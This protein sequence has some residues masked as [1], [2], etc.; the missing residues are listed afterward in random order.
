MPLPE[1]FTARP[2]TIDDL[3][4]AAELAN[5]CAMDLIGQ[6]IT[7]ANELRIDWQ[8]P[9]S[10]LE[11][12][13]H[14]V[15]A[16]DA[17]SASALVGYAGVWDAAP[18]VQ[19]HSWS[20]VHPAYRDCG[21][22]DYLIEW[23]E[24]R[25]RQAIP[26][27]PEGARVSVEQMKPDT[28][29]FGGERLIAH[30]YSL[31]RYFLEMQIEMTEPPPAPIFP[32]S[33][34]M[35]SMADLPGT[36]AEQVRAVTL[37][38]QEMFRDHWGFFEQPIDE[39]VAD[40]IHW[41]DNDRDHDPRLWFLAV[42]GN[43]IVGLALCSPKSPQDPEMA[44]VISLGVKRPWRKQG[45]A[46]AM[47]HYSFGQFY[48]RGIRKVGLGVDAQSLTGAT[49]LYERAGMR[50]ARKEALYEKELRPGVELSTQ[51]LPEA[52]THD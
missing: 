41:V 12:D 7:N 46:L 18:H 52:D 29:V 23:T 43:Q 31:A 47:L 14:L 37:A 49:R 40:W 50:P 25:A 1:R 26:Q 34:Q 4:R 15:F 45:I 39:A 44:C 21:L 48:Q 16:A 17:P 6:P 13:I 5:L 36:H 10:N 28:D 27:A 2:A 20:Y 33:V 42:Q 9:S 11:T 30:G 8:L 35:S 19:A 32:S 51:S 24:A 38:D 3:E 22:D